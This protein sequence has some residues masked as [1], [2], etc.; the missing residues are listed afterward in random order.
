M[1]DASER[2]KFCLHPQKHLSRNLS[3]EGKDF[4][5]LRQELAHKDG[6]SLVMP[7]TIHPSRYSTGKNFPSSFPPL[8]IVKRKNEIGRSRLLPSDSSRQRSMRELSVYISPTWWT[9]SRLALSLRRNQPR[10]IWHNSFLPLP[11]VHSLMNDVGNRQFCHL[12]HLMMILHNRISMYIF[13]RS[14]EWSNKYGKSRTLELAIQYLVAL[15]NSRK[16]L[17]G[18]S[19]DKLKKCTLQLCLT[20]ATEILLIELSFLQCPIWP[21]LPLIISITW[22]VRWWEASYIIMK[23]KKIAVIVKLQFSNLPL[24]WQGVKYVQ[25]QEV[26]VQGDQYGHWLKL[27]MFCYPA[28]A[29]GS[30]SSCQTRLCQRHVSI[31]YYGHPVIMSH[32]S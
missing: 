12:V 17:G 3:F 27:W 23:Y 10:G 32:D 29:A 22:L 26:Y 31:A 28:W 14:S 1:R 2:G 6:H 7:L 21:K 4:L 30:Y 15:K 19:L 13:S 16:I 18:L 20:Q 11:Q 24:P 8:L 5:I 25:A 9:Q